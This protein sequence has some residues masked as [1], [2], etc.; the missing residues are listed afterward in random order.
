MAAQ[1]PLKDI[2]HQNFK[3]Y[4]AQGAVLVDKAPKEWIAA[5]DVADCWSCMLLE[6]STPQ[7][8]DR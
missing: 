2:D 6:V 1:E 8:R 7:A 5:L 3:L 4:V